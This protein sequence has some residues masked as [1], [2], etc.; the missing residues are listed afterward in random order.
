[1]HIEN[2]YI[3]FFALSTLMRQPAT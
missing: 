2:N 3:I 1:M